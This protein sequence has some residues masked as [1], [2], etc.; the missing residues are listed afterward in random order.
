MAALTKQGKKT[1]EVLMHELSDPIQDL[2]MAYGERCTMEASLAFL[3]K[4][5]N[6]ENKKVMTMLF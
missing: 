6:A 1:F 2:A 5:K 4:L 3:E